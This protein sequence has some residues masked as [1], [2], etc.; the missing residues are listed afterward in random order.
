MYDDEDDD[1]KFLQV[2]V[3]NEF[4]DDFDLKITLS[5]R[6]AGFVLFSEIYG[7]SKIALKF[8]RNI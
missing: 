8:S 2:A 4:F 1:C 3:V 5:L 6:S 7:Q